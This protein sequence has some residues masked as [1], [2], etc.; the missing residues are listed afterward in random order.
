M[1]GALI[2]LAGLAACLPRP[3]SADDV[4]ACN[5]AIATAE[6]KAAMPKRVMGTIALVESGRAIGKQVVPWP[7]SINVGGAGYYYASKEEA[8]EAVRTFTA[9]GQ[10]SI[11]VG[12]MQINLAAHP[13][14]FAS[15]DTAFEPS[16]N[17]EY[18]AGFLRTL[19]QQSGRF[20]TAMT[21][22][23][24]Q[25]PEFANDYARRLLAVWPGAA[26]LGLTTNAVPS[27]PASPQPISK[28]NLDTA[29]GL[30]L[31]GRKVF[32]TS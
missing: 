32:T 28:I 1:R 8:I 29:V 2:L 21:A 13:A 11:D 10:R 14:A 6:R 25:T 24:S 19:Y 4:T 31:D 27:P 30:A 15:L 16:T 9:A 17:A 26:Q 7:W 23:H 3:A 18:A 5:A 22:Y 20:S 12:C